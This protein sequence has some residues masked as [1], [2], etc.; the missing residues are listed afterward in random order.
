[1][2]VKLTV[3]KKY[4]EEIPVEAIAMYIS[5]SISE[6]RDYLIGFTLAMV[7]FMFVS[8]YVIIKLKI[9]GP[10]KRLT[11]FIMSSEKSDVDDDIK[12]N[13]DSFRR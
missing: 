11:E 9:I 7:L 3:S 8:T 6:F 4:N 2:K 5:K 1:M 10:I 13:V 12:K